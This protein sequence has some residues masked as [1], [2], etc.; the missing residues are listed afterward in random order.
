M[1]AEML[2]DP[3]RDPRLAE[4][5]LQTQVPCPSLTEDQLRFSILDAGRSRLAQLRAR[6][7]PWWEWTAGWAR[8]AV[9]VGLA[10]SLA[11]GVLLVRNPSVVQS[12][13]SAADS[14]TASGVMLSAAAGT[15][16]SPQVGDELVAEASDDWL[17]TQVMSR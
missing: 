10:A 3:E 8:V 13:A 16:G 14:V 2:A 5:L 9:P 17:L 11:A 1:L 6:Q 4:A 12:A 7:R 15:T